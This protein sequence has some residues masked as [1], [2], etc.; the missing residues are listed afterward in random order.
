[1]IG[2][3]QKVFTGPD[4]VVH[5]MPLLRRV[6]T[7]MLLLEPALGTKDCAYNPWRE[8]S[9]CMGLESQH[10]SPNPADTVKSP[11]TASQGGFSLD[12]MDLFASLD[13]DALLGTA[14]SAATQPRALVGS[15]TSASLTALRQTSCPTSCVS[16]QSGLQAMPHQPYPQA[17][18]TSA[19]MPQ[20]RPVQMPQAF[21]TPQMSQAHPQV[22]PFNLLIT[23]TPAISIAR[24]G[25]SCSAEA[26]QLTLGPVP[27]WTSISA[28][29]A[30][31][32]DIPFTSQQ[33]RVHD[34]LACLYLT[35]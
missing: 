3:M 29:N 30:V 35:A 31:S 25:Q 12:G 21:F 27:G 16:L 33:V 28:T 24:G 23:Q 4:L 17:S 15:D 22:A 34:A 20:A 9:F 32:E 5:R 26:G 10:G 19:K 7:V 8:G 14:A 13:M 1:M 2:P 6:S 18:H 11:Q